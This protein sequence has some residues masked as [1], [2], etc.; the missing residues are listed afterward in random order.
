M[1]PHH[2]VIVG[3]GFGG[4]YAAKALKDAPVQITLVDKN[5]YHLFQPL[6]Y[7]VAMAG[8]SPGDIA[9]PLRRIFRQQ[10]NVRTLMGKVVDLDAEDKSVS[11]RHE[12]E[13]NEEIGASTIGY[14][15][16]IIATGIQYAYFGNEEWAKLA[17]SLKSVENALEI[18]RRVLY[19]YE[20][21]EQELNPEKRQAW[22]T[23]AVVGAGPTGME[24]AGALA[25]MAYHTLDGE[26]RT[27]DPDE[28]QVILIEASDQVMP[29]YKP[30]SGRRAQR[31][32]EE[33]GVTVR[34]NTKV[35]ALADDHVK[36][37]P[38]G[39]DEDETEEIACRTILWGAGTQGTP[40]AKTLAERTGVELTKK[41][42]VK[43][44]ADWSVGNYR[45]VFV[46]GDLGHFTHDPN[47]ES[48]PGVAQVAI[49]GGKYVAGVIQKRIEGKAT[50]PF[51]YFDK[52]QM[53]TIGR[54][55]AV[56]EIGPLR[57]GG[58]PAWAAWL[59]VHIVYLVGFNNR[60]QVFLQWLWMYLTYTRGVRLII[61][62]ERNEAMRV[63]LNGQSSPSAVNQQ[64]NRQKESATP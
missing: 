41:G 49:Q 1:T 50:R 19:A 58:F 55:A 63:H 3:G 56:A 23:F 4:L 42:M 15:S 16:L 9:E 18:R 52:G 8:L 17:P 13:S 61:E 47:F 38:T 6:L 64:S 25:E 60:I 46:I 31:Q 24:L 28:T 12:N 51:R 35:T 27:I 57:F 40:L 34:L 30:D 11:L 5:N 45:N 48:L 33:K 21:A 7:Q 20:M 43:V 26:F 62:P 53:A 2:V 59:L 10:K 44:N 29:P 22:L 54:S 36:V 14:D 32:L 37:K 39:G